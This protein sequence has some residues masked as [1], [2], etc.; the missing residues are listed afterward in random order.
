MQRGAVTVSLV[1]AVGLGCLIV[2]GGAGAFIVKRN[3]PPDQTA[4][5]AQAIADQ[6]AAIADLAAEVNK[7]AVLSEEVK[8]NLAGDVPAGCREAAAS[9]EP[10]CIAMACQRT[11]QSAA[12]RCDTSMVAQL[13]AEY[14]VERRELACNGDTDCVDRRGDLADKVK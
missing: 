5:T 12:G 9:M 7:P 14:L 3:T 10:I 8:A 13:V 1:V 2:G 4:E 11:Q 6:T